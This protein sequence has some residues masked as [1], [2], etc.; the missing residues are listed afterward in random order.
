MTHSALRSI[1]IWTTLLASMTSVA[2][3]ANVTRHP[4]AGGSK[5]P[6]ARA[7]E[8]PAGTT[9]VFHSGITPTPADPKA[10]E[11]SAAY[12]GDTKTQALSAFARIKESLDSLGLG[13]GDVISMT[14]YLVGDPAKQGRMDFAG[15]MEAYSQ[16]FGTPAQP[17][18]PSRSTV[19]VAGLVAPG[20]LVEI[21][22]TLAR[23]KR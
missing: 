5:F 2:H 19:Q 23:P 22:V 18:L 15:F 11:G 16:H 8:V 7:V 17:N 6:I 9:L 3:A 4:L 1:L 10:P 13:F 20:M 12:W 21:E 14:V